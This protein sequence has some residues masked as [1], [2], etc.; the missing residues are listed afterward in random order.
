MAKIYELNDGTL[1]IFDYDTFT[2]K[3]TELLLKNRMVKGKYSQQNVFQDIAEAL[4][5]SEETVKKWYKAKSSPSDLDK[6][7]D[8]ADYL[9]MEYMDLLSDLN[10]TNILSPPEPSQNED[11]SEIEVIETVFDKERDYKMD[12]INTSG[13]NFSDTKSIVRSIYMDLCDYVF[14]VADNSGIENLDDLFDFEFQDEFDY[15]KNQIETNNVLENIR[16][17]LSSYML[18]IPI[19]QFNRIKELVDYISEMPLNKLL[20]YDSSFPSYMYDYEEVPE[21]TLI[22]DSK[23]EE[24]LNDN[25]FEID[26][27]NPIDYYCSIQHVYEPR[28]IKHIQNEFLEKSQE[29]FAEFIT[30]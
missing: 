16:Y 24:Y 20:A 9:N 17:K 22:L 26:K 3:V 25:G 27:T 7:K 15:I 6:I 8:L 30:K 5:S 28:F 10:N 12:K 14:R 11:I 1:T 21:H 4:N 23:Y 2:A 29:V 18:D 19:S 13:I